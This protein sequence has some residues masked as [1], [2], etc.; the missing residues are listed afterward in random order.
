MNKKLWIVVLT[1]A[2]FLPLGVQVGHVVA[3]AVAN[4]LQ[5]I[6]ADVVYLSSDYLEGREAGTQGE[7]LAADYIAW[8][9][10]QIGLQPRGHEG[11]W[12][13]EFDF[14]FN[15]NPHAQG[16]EA[17]TG[18]N[19]VG[20]IDNGAP[21]TVVIGAHYDHL[22][23]GAF[24]SLYTG[25]PAI[26]NGA[27]DNASG[28]AAMLR[29]AE[30][31]RQSGAAKSNNYL[32]LAFSAEEL[33]LVG[34]KKWVN[35]PTLALGSINYMFNLDMVGRLNEEK[36][37]LIT[38]TGTSP[39]WAPILAQLKVAGIQIRSSESGVGPSDHTSF[40]LQNMPVLS[41]FTGQH[42]DYHKPVDDAHL[43]NYQGI[44]EITQLAVAIIEQTSEAGKLVFTPTKDENE[45]KQAARFKVS[46]GVMPDYVYGGTGLRV[47]SVIEGRVGAKAGIKAGDIIVKLGD[48]EISDIYTYMEGLASFQTG[49]STTVVVKRG[50]SE[51]SMPVK[52]E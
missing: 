26:H 33:G 5:Q 14:N 44:Y 16:G 22:G 24:G 42:S 13:H 20:F 35:D 6:K 46:L 1:I 36:S 8:R 28:V 2:A 49:N 29:I 4:P 23:Y 19:V 43:I 30:H 37:L 52:F 21:T 47:D 18:R 41:F 48:K 32:F 3:Q 25:E 40:Y 11:S 27:D 17:R 15:T 34:S 12:F 31:L 9:F 50:E 7:K 39:S 45:N 51:I 10:A 38:G